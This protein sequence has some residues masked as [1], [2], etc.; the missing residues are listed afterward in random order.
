M[1]VLSAEALVGLVALLASLSAVI[2]S[3]RREA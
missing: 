3:I 2:W 1:L